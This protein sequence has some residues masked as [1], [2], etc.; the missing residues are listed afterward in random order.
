MLENI[1][2][3][4]YDMA[5]EMVSVTEASDDWQPHYEL[6]QGLGCSEREWNSKH[7]AKF[8]KTWKN[9]I[10]T[11]KNIIKQNH[12]E[13]LVDT[14][15]DDPK[16]EQYLIKRMDEFRGG[17]VDRSDGCMTKSL[18]VFTFKGKGVQRVLQN[19]VEKTLMNAV[20][21]CIPSEYEKNT[22]DNP[23]QFKIGLRSGYDVSKRAMLSAPYIYFDY[24]EKAIKEHEKEK[25]KEVKEY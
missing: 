5:L 7:R 14:I 13:N 15:S 17:P 1:D 18:F 9:M 3:C 24:V 25:K 10:D 20:T 16:E 22:P 2:N 19:R 6:L 23:L 4:I 12:W 21:K 8:I 11:V